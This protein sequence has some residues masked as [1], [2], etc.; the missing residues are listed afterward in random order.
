MNPLLAAYHEITLAVYEISETLANQWMI[1][2]YEYATFGRDRFRNSRIHRIKSKL[3]AIQSSIYP[4]RR[5]RSFPPISANIELP[6]AER[7]RMTHEMK[8]EPP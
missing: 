8:P 3:F 7:R 1:V 2:D 6:T 5:D 4:A